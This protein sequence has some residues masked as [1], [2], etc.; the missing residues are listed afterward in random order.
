MS[1][2]SFFCPAN[3]SSPAGKEC[4]A[5]HYCPAST[6]FAS[7]FP[8]PRGTYKPQ[9]GGAQ[10]SDCTPCEPGKGTVSY[11]SSHLRPRPP[12]SAGGTQAWLRRGCSGHSPQCTNDQHTFI[13][14][15]HVGCPRAGHGCPEL[16]WGAPNPGALS[17]RLPC[18]L[19]LS[20]AWPGG[21]VRALPCRIPLYS[22]SLCPKSH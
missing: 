22:G 10:R 14:Q 19:L 11:P 3:T 6:A 20:P 2:C 15:L 8:C 16:D 5:G 18:R 7:Q 4:P 9:R 17:F 21:R 13:Y 1:T 12:A